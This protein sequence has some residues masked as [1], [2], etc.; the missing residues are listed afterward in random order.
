MFASAARSAIWLMSDQAGEILAGVLHVWQEVSH[1]QI[2]LDQY[3]GYRLAALLQSNVWTGSYD[4]TM[5]I[6]LLRWL[7]A[8]AKVLV[9]F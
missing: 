1:R 6:L 4:I 8:L 5:I 3:Y 9:H 2:Q 7:T